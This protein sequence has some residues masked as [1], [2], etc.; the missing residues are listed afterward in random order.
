MRR[1]DYSRSDRDCHRSGSKR[2]RSPGTSP[3]GY[4]S[5]KHDRHKRSK[6]SPRDRVRERGSDRSGRHESRDAKDANRREIEENARNMVGKGVDG[7]V[8]AKL[9]ADLSAKVNKVE[10]EK[11]EAVEREM[12]DSLGSKTKDEMSGEKEKTEEELKVRRQ[13]RLK[14]WR[15]QKKREEE[16]VKASLKMSGGE[17]K[18]HDMIEPK[19]D[20]ISNLDNKEESSATPALSS[21]GGGG[22]IKMATTTVIGVR[23]RGTILQLV[24]RKAKVS[25]L[26]AE[27]EADAEDEEEDAG[28]LEEEE[29]RKR[30][31]TTAANITNEAAASAPVNESSPTLLKMVPLAAAA[32]AVVAESVVEEE[33]STTL[34][35][36]KESQKGEEE[37]PL[38]AFMT[39]LEKSDEIV[40][41]DSIYDIGMGI[42]DGMR[43]PDAARMADVN[44]LGSNT[45][46]LDE[47]LGSNGGSGKRAMWESDTGGD[48]SGIEDEETPAGRRSREEREEKEKADFIGA[49]RR[50]DATG[51]RAVGAHKDE[52]DDIPKNGKEVPVEELGRMW[53]EEGDVMEEHER[54]SKE[55]D[56]L[57]VRYYLG[58]GS[59]GIVH[60]M[61]YVSMKVYNHCC[62]AA[63][64]YS[65]QVLAE[66]VKKKEL[67][68]VDHSTISYIPIRKNL[69]IVPRSLAALPAKEIQEVR[70]SLEIK[71]RGRGCPPPIETWEQT[72]VSD[73]IIAVIDR[74]DWKEPFPIQKQAI[75]AIMGG[76][77]V[78]GVAKTGSG[79]TLAFL[80]P[81]FRH[82]L[83]QPP[84]GDREGPI[85]LIM[86]PAREL[87]VQIY[88]ECKRFTKALALRVTAV[89][90]GAGV[91]DQIADLKRGAEIVVCTP[92]RM[93]ELLTMQS[94]KMI[95]LSRISYVVM[96]EADRMF[97]MGF[98]PQIKMILQNIRHDRQVVLFSATFP[99]K[100][101]TLAKK[102]LHVPLEIIVGGRSVASSNITQYVEVRD[103]DDKYLRLLQLLGTW[104]DRGHVLI[105]VDTQSRADSLF[106]DLTKSGYPALSL[107]GGKDQ[108]DR[109]FTIS[110]FKNGIR[111]LMVATS[112]AG[113]GLD[114][115]ELVCVINYSCPNHLEDYVHRVGRT[116]R[117]GRPG[118][119]YTFI[120]PEE[121]MHSPNLMKA[122]TQSE[123]EVPA[124]LQAMSDGFLAKV[125]AGQAKYAH[126]G[127][128][129]HGF[130]FD[131]C[132]MTEEQK[133]RE[134]EKKLYEVE[135]GLRD[136]SDLI[137]DA[138]DAEA[139]LYM[140]QNEENPMAPSAPSA[141]NQSLVLVGTED[142]VSDPFAASA[143]AEAQKKTAAHMA[144][145]AAMSLPSQLPVVSD[146]I[147]KA[148]EEAAIAKAN[149]AMAMAPSLL[150]GTDSAALGQG[151]GGSSVANMV[152][153]ARSVA[154]SLG[155]TPVQPTPAMG[156]GGASV[157]GGL[158]PVG[159]GQATTVTLPSGI[160]KK[161]G[162]DT[163]THFEYTLVIN[164][165]PQLARWKVT[166][167]EQINQVIERTGVAVT[168]RGMYVAPGKVIA[169]GEEK[170]NLRIESPDE[171]QVEHAINEFKRIL[172]DETLRV[173][174][175][176]VKAGKYRV[177]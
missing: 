22:D 104:Y 175:Q 64:I 9:A 103:E 91:A 88:N 28:K 87:A 113:R 107:H 158:A 12:M 170:L 92:G 21:V 30:S 23:K 57:Q 15:E 159:F 75:P 54:K 77:D 154:M 67:K 85:G 97:D 46:T 72:G 52:D 162:A 13:E 125:K 136:S 144:S 171:L 93:I 25:G 66:S 153:K 59:G 79:K 89:Y 174:A 164:D 5:G 41:Q 1:R 160:L 6:G 166:Q 61:N 82:I 73:R 137:D 78:I 7:D 100:V 16:E 65:I 121:E 18:G 112:V 116:G 34:S 115:P 69:Y 45:I 14:K 105:F 111:T 155:I 81:M 132:E 3:S 150:E 48:D 90:G 114:V 50:H 134:Q 147:A 42:E 47:L 118:T 101:E 76:R 37:D 39:T 109:D 86:A 53:A 129:G 151:G 63:S 130:T 138:A 161:I 99:Q 98:E 172:S 40:E 126:S 56:A 177:V 4:P 143:E 94:G 68:A 141:L 60:L 44:A 149:A 36:V 108:S 140:T 11:L 135:Q 70:R 148:A 31:V 145:L 142:I 62:T 80:L 24:G 51:G 71:I 2:D 20:H 55:K 84:L 165:Y 156:G 131:E 169:V 17:G 168:A 74:H 139:E 10:A 32:T 173:A 33:R 122:L 27:W 35:A 8:L 102:V 127:F 95:N 19:K 133:I 119:A 120:S 157:S 128:G 43:K 96:D 58:G 123:Q 146:P 83:D 106:A 49:L 38:D 29:K 110:D 152:A 117:A 167:K 163:K 176:P 26:S 124:E